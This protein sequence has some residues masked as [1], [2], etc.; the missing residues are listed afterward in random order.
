MCFLHSIPRSLTAA[1]AIAVLIAF[2]VAPISA[3]TCYSFQPDPEDLYDLS[4]SRYYTWNVEWEVPPGEYITYATLSVDQLNDYKIE[5]DDALYIHL[6]DDAEPG[7]AKHYDSNDGDEFAGQ[8]LLLTTY[9]DDNEYWDGSDWV[10]PPE[11]LNYDFTGSDLSMLTTYAS[12]G[13]FALGFDPDCHYYNC[14]MELKIY[15]HPVPEPG[16][17]VLLTSALGMLG[18]LKRR[19]KA[20]RE[21]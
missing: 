15:T 11:D 12:D 9:V 10:N 16:T 7:V 21:A 18:L 17:W 5:D 3:D 14:G 6:L 2:C 4:H 20:N 8:G 1:S 19:R 13:Q